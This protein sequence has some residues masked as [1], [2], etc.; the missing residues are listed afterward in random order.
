MA[1]A[2][3][4]VFIGN[5]EAQELFGTAAHSALA[6]SIIV[7]DDQELVLKRGSGSASVMVGATEISEP[8]L[9]AEMIE[10]TGAGDAFA[11]GY[12]A[13]TV[14]GWKVRARLRLG[15]LMASRT[16]AVLDHV[17]PPLSETD[18]DMLSPTWLETI[19]ATAEN[20]APS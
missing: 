14:F 12:L 20:H 10:S 8:S 11:A 15:H 17:A 2:A 9:P 5:D 6:E 4:I 19:W 3:D 13:G 1:R 18:L 16:I 7:R